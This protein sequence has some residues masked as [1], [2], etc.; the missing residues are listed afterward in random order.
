MCKCVKYSNLAP[1]TRDWVPYVTL[2]LHAILKTDAI[3]DDGPIL[4]P[5]KLPKFRYTFIWNIYLIINFVMSLLCCWSDISI[6]SVSDF[7]LALRLQKQFEQEES[8]V[9]S[10]ENQENSFDEVRRHWNLVVR[11]FSALYY[12]AIADH[13]GHTW[14]ICAWKLNEPFSLWHK[15]KQNFFLNSLCCVCNRQIN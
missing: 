1:L 13:N 4:L 14:I 6:M 5:L 15:F 3:A 7:E 2:L 12:T 11:Y 10:N 9:V 8:N